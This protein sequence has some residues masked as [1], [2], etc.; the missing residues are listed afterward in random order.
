MLLTLLSAVLF[1]LAFPITRYDCSLWPLAFI[2]LG[3][4]VVSLE[5]T[6]SLPRQ[7]LSG[8]LWGSVV[9]LGRG[10]WLFYAM[11]GEYHVRIVPA[12]L[13]MLFGVMAPFA[14]IYGFLGL[15]FGAARNRDILS[16]LI[17]FPSI[18]VLAEYS[19]EIIPFLVPWGLLGY[20]VQ[21]WNCYIQMADSTGVY[22]ISFVL[23]LCNGG[24]AYLC[25]GV[26]AA[27]FRQMMKRGVA[28]RVVRC[29]S[30]NR[31]VC[32]LLALAMLLPLS[33][34]AARR[35]A[36][37][38]M[39]ERNVTAGKVIP[40]TIAQPNFT[41]EE[42]WKSTGFID[43]VNVCLGLTGR[44]ALP[45]VR[46]EEEKGHA[47]PGSRGLVVWP[48]TVLNSA[49]NVNSMLLDHFRARLPGFG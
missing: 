25:R 5:R 32:V 37:R 44:C 7:F 34:G 49:G 13:V 6:G 16:H 11:I 24:V 22:G 47:I 18:W 38:E 45:P 12:L 19:R 33:Y 31:A 35:F 29:L 23:A 20:A 4:L 36:V 40:V 2:C 30:D 39:V 8:V 28:A 43:R 27:T 17:L 3:P 41:Q 46:G 48:E 1:I 15:V 26:N 21:P 14:L 10:Y 42:R 9:A